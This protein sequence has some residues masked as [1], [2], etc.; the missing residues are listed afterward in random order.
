[1]NKKSISPTQK[2]VSV[3]VLGALSLVISFVS[4]PI[5]PA[6]P[7]LKLDFGDIPILLGTFG[8]GPGAGVL[9]ALIKSGLHYV[10]TAGEFGIPIGDTASFLASL[11]LTLP[12]YYSV[13]HFGYER[14]GKTIGTVFAS[15]SLSVVMAILNYTVLLPMYLK[16][17]S[18]SDFG[19][20][21]IS[22]YI[23]LAVLPF[24]LVKGVIISLTFFIVWKAI[25]PYME[26]HFSKLR[27]NRYV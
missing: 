7:F 3:A 16:V 17:M 4:F 22:E 26:K 19:F 5:F 11:S 21:S 25:S 24:N 2:L 1:M 6:T 10:L 12:L 9:I 23:V 27:I 20:A 14:K 15:I 18:I 13:K 8:F